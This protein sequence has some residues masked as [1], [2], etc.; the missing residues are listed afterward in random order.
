MRLTAWPIDRIKRRQIPLRHEPLALIETTGGRQVVAMA[1]ELAQSRGVRRGMTLAEA[2]ALCSGL[3]DAPHE[4]ANDLRGLEALGRWLMR[5]SPAVALEPPAAI[6]LEIGGS[7]RLFGSLERLR[8]Q[9]I[10]ALQHLHLHAIVAIG[11]TAGAA[12][13]LTYC[14]HNQNMLC[15]ISAAVPGGSL[16]PAIEGTELLSALFRLP[17]GALR[18]SSAIAELLFQLGIETIGQ[19][20]HLPRNALPARFGDELLRRLDQA[21]GRMPEPLVTLPFRTPI[22]SS[23]RFEAPLD[24]LETIWIVLKQLIADVVF[25]LTRRGCG[26]RQ[27]NARFDRDGLPAIEQ[28]IRLSSPSRDP[29]NLFNLLR[30]TLEHIRTDQGFIGITLHAVVFERIS[31]DQSTLIGNEDDR[32]RKEFGRLIERL[33]ARLGERSVETVQ[34]IESHLPERVCRYVDAM[35]KSVA[36]SAVAMLD[37]PDRYPPRA[38]RPL[39]LLPTPIEISVMVTPSEDREGKPISF[40]H[41]GEVHRIV[42]AIGPER[43]AGMWWGGHNKTRDYFE[44]E[45]EM[46]RCFWIFRVNES[47]RWFLQGV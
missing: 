8:Q 22:Q 30:C 34:L 7:E 29:T 24:A 43:I 9:V 28:T 11:P 1:C 13:A 15:E 17:P 44:V 4:P 19:L 21:L 37:E 20:V 45:D 35:E 47:F 31:E 32:K 38:S 33:C 6:Y 40:T 41:R 27:L 26:V 18:I 10:D 42:Y 3:R 39:Q 2:R 12:Y 14:S 25:E 46:G 5:F 23:L 16:P 36:G